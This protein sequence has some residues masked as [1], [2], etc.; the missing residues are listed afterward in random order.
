MGIAKA[1]IINFQAHKHSILEFDKGL[2]VIHGD[3]GQGKSCVLRSINWVIN[4]RPQGFSFQNKETKKPTQVNLTVDDLEIIR[5]RGKSK[6]QYELDNDTFKALRSEVPKE[7]TELLNLS[8]YCYRSQHDQ[9][10]LFNDSDGEVAKKINKVTGLSI[11]DD[12]MQKAKH[13][14]TVNNQNI[15]TYQQEYTYYRE[16]FNS[17][18]GLKLL[19]KKYEKLVDMEKENEELK[20]THTKLSELVENLKRTQSK[21]DALAPILRTARAVEQAIELQNSIE[22]LFQQY[23][24]LENFAIYYSEVKTKYNRVKKISSLEIDKSILSEIKES[25]QNYS[26]LKSLIENINSIQ[27][28]IGMEKFKIKQLRKEITGIKNQLNIC[29]ICK[30][31]F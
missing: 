1:E 5:V 10:F 12:V 22:F 3:N 14:K 19:K 25:K 17:Y 2:N 16:K 20:K 23:E 30:K 26:S 6:N 27:N 21:V 4:N 15:N 13:L 28:D 8:E 24:Q 7:I 9:Y 18:K 29:P 31:P 11:I